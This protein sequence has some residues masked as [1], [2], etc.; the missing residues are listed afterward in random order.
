[1]TR[2]W[3]YHRNL[4]IH[5]G[6]LAPLAVLLYQAFRGELTV[7]PIQE[8]TFRTG[9][10]ALMLLIFTLACTP[11]NTVFGFRQ[12]L[13]WRRA[14]GLY[15]FLYAAIHLT[16][17]VGLDYG[18]DWA[19]IQGAIL[20]KRYA[21]AGLAAFLALLPLA[22]TSTRG[23]QRRLKKR[24]KKLHHLIYVA[25]VLAIVH[26]V[27]LVKADIR[28][29]LLYGGVVMILL[30]LRWPPVRRTASQIRHRLF[31]R[32]RRSAEKTSPAGI[33]KPVVGE[34]PVEAKAD[35]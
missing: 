2:R 24:W 17:F 9:K 19:L 16:I 25:A 11:L 21:L 20:E 33:L 1:M 32:R 15:A 30:L 12:A 23:W 18:F 7:N 8:A 3:V 6:A 35:R 14:L 26:Y 10:T 28:V 5:A 29:P 22:I 34:P 4:L 13:R 31:R 27:W